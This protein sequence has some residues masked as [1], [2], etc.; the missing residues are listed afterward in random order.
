MSNY[1]AVPSG[2]EISRSIADCLEA[3]APSGYLF[4]ERARAIRAANSILQGRS[5]RTVADLMME[6][7]K[8]GDDRI[9]NVQKDIIDFQL[10]KALLSSPYVQTAD[11]NQDY[12]FSYYQNA[13]GRNLKIIDQK[14]YDEAVE[15]GFPPHFFQ[16]SYFEKVTFYCLPDQ[17][18]FLGSEF[19][20]CR[21]AVC[22]LER[23][24]FTCTRIYDSEFYSSVLNHVDLSRASLVHTRFCDCE[25]THVMFKM[26]RM[27]CC[28]VVDCALD[29]IDFSWATLDDCSFDRVSACKISLVQ[30]TI[31][32]SGATEEEYRQKK[33]AI[34][35]ALGM[36]TAVA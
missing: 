1:K 4:G 17:T 11:N 10:Q 28:R 19:H 32:Q 2:M 6:L 13:D 5:F 35:Q 9:D 7:E 27:K 25:L 8:C 34:F 26:A 15:H 33:A 30:A 12:T 14:L 36:A 21:F 18:D 31:A 23:A 3:V 24:S 22:R 16:E 20:Y 29:D